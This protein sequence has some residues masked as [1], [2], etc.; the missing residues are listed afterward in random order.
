MLTWPVGIVDCR[1][2]AVF[3]PGIRCRHMPSWEVPAWLL[4]LHGWRATPSGQW[5][6]PPGDAHP[7]A[8]LPSDRSD[9]APTAARVEGV[10]RPHGG[11]EASEDTPRGRRPRAGQRAVLQQS[12]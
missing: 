8:R 7:D 11:S 12:D 3:Q 1:C 10:L 6:A 4:C 5:P 9:R 2:A